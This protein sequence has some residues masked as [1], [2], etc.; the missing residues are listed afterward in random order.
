MKISPIDTLKSIKTEQ[1]EMRYAEI[2]VSK[3]IQLIG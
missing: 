3:G 1:F 2:K